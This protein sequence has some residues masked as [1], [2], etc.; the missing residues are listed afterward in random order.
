[1]T[2]PTREA[3]LEFV[4]VTKTYPGIGDEPPATA[5]PEFSLSVGAAELVVV[6]GRSGSGKTTMLQLGAALLPPTRGQVR[7]DGRDVATITD[8]DLSAFRRE[9][10]GIIFQDAGL[11]STLTAAENVAL[12]SYAQ[13]RRHRRGDPARVS[14]L[15]SDVGLQARRNHLPRQ[16]SGGERQRVAL[17]R[18]LYPQPRLL[19][20]DEPTASLD[21][22]RADD[23]IRILHTLCEHGT[24]VL[25]AS[26][27]PVL[28][29][30]AQKVLRLEQD[31]NAS[32]M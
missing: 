25:V 27:D 15:L 21:R 31:A 9:Q 8:A 3:V 30:S 26:H 2:V 5:L 28:T 32:A 29:D 4:A 7:W 17:A 14:Q 1:M 24:T 22:R 23:V 18:A 12:S 10:L 19:L 6:S 11:I 13:P 20:V 16:L